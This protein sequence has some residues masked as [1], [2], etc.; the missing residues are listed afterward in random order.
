VLAQVIAVAGG[1]VIQKALGG[2][3]RARTKGPRQVISQLAG[4]RT[5]ARRLM[6]AIMSARGSAKPSV[7]RFYLSYLDAWQHGAISSARKIVTELHQRV[8]A[9]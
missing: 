7:A 8:L 4:D 6:T 1:E 3:M 9:S 5:A 2:A